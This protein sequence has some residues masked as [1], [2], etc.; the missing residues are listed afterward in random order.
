MAT[1]SDKQLANHKRAQGYISATGATLGIAALG[2]AGVKS[3]IGRRGSVKLSRSA[4]K[5]G[6]PRVGGAIVRGQR[7]SGA[8]ATNLTVGSAGV[9][10]VGGYNFAAI[11]SQE[12]RRAKIGKS[13][14]GVDH[15]INP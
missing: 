14:W 3:P 13:I 4:N 15:G 7:K 6:K 1:W 11:Q 9:G 10:G 8:A 12:S 5:A 2:A